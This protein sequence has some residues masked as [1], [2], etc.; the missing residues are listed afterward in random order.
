MSTIAL[1][2]NKINNMPGY[3]S[4][5]RKS[6][7]NFKSELFN[8]KSSS[9]AVNKNICNLDDVISNVSATTQIQE[10]KI[11][12]LEDFQKKNEQFIEDTIK[13]DSNVA[14][15]VNQNK[16]DFY[17]EY[18]YLKPDCEKSGWEKF[19]DGCKKAAQWCKENWKSIAKIIVAVVIVAALGIAS[20]LT[21]G[22]L[23]VILAGAFWG[24]LSGG[25]IGGII[26]G[27]TSAINGG[28]FLDGFADGLLSGVMTGA[29][30]GAAFT[31]IGVAGQAFG[32]G[33]SC[34]SKLGQTIKITSKVTKVIS[35]GMDGFDLLAMGIGFF[36]PNNPLV[37]INQ[38]LHS[39]ALYNVLQIGV[40]AAAIFTGAATTTMKCFV[41]GTMV[42]TATGLVAIENIKAGDKVISTS[43][44]TFEVA[45]KTVLETYVRETTNLVV[46]T[47]NG[48]SI[49]TTFDHPF[50]VKDEGFIVAG[51]LY[52]GDKLFD[53]NSKTVI[54][55]NVQFENTD[56]PIKVYNFQ[57]E[58]FHTYH[59]GSYGVC[60]HNASDAY[61]ILRKA[62]PSAEIKDAINSGDKKID[63]V[64][65]YEVDKLEADHIMSLKEITEQPGFDKLSLS[66]QI[67]VANTPENFM[68]LGKRTNA[69]KGAKPI[70]EWEG[71]SKLG[72]ISEEIKQYLLEKDE[73][74]R[75]AIRDAIEKRLK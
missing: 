44:E 1:Y 22:A 18:N 39:L 14:D 55:E 31:G 34:L 69:S 8:L 33:V 72:T 58:D 71:H 53:S 59:V 7:G 68:G 70:S 32:K 73:I 61:K 35:F 50:Y 42:L 28:S 54:V 29:V 23:A 25:L 19:C 9:L 13:I 47:V 52:I 48:E 75:K 27:I 65:G 74:A 57:V 63:P 3:I 45:E 6:V 49:R 16:S 12:A 67:E 37:Q 4:D 15:V 5:M 36:D 21:G 62:S 64:Y 38:K 20:V 17:D 26:G 46:L 51:K 40:N 10:Q 2:A 66:D 41:A 56:E 60:V 11:A 24:A 30:T 43:P